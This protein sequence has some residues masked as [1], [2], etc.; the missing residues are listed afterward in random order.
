MGSDRLR[1]ILDD[2][3]LRN[4]RTGVGHY[5]AELIATLPQVAPDL[6]VLAFCRR[7]VTRGESPQAPQGG[8]EMMKA[9]RPA[10]GR[11]PYWARRLVQ[12]TY[13]TAF[14]ALGTLLGY[15]IYHEPNH[16]PSPWPGPVVTTI[17]DLSALRFPA[18]HPPDRVAWYE[19]SFVAALPRSSHFI[20]VSEFTRREM[21]DL[22]G[23]N[24]ERITAIPLGVR[25]VFHPRP[26]EAVEAWR[27][28]RGLSGGY[29][30]FVGT[31]EPRKN[32]PG[33]LVAYGRLP[34]S[35][36]RRFPLVI[37][38][39]GGW[40]HERLVDL[41]VQE[42]LSPDVRM[43]GYVSDEEL[44]WLYAG[45]RVLVWPTFYEGFGLPPLECMASG[46]PVVTS[47]VASL[48]EVVGDAGVL[49]DP[50]DVEGFTRAVARILVDEGWA[51]ELA[52]AGLARS[53]AFSWLTCGARHAEIYRQFAE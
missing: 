11:W 48:P 17:H 9:P 28:S 2:R 49:V 19:R 10:R 23:I 8:A 44:A 27:K 20:T 16:I 21:V 30:L 39:A 53:K 25:A 52:Q 15:R 46:T 14:E 29:V 22:L 40:A 13:G 42:N 32:L 24:P 34:E 33:L 6:D 26:A 5:V 50:H 41:V 45:A 31:H 37:A 4:V 43:L 35:L 47:Q 51:G 7:F 38:G 18:W 3:C 1:V 36:R 12:E